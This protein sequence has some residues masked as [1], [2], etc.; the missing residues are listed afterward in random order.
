MTGQ[1]R[2]RQISIILFVLSLITLA[3]HIESL[4]KFNRQDSYRS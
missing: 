4:V 3:V 2:F 1:N